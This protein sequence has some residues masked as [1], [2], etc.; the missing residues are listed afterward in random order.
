MLT[1][2]SFNVLSESCQKS[3]L[4]PVKTPEEIAKK[5]GVSLAKIH[6]Q[7]K[8]GTKVEHEH[9][10]DHDT[11]MHIALHHLDELPDYYTRL[12]KV[13]MNEGIVSR[14]RSVGRAAKRAV[15][16]SLPNPVRS[17][18]A[19]TGVTGMIHN[20]DKTPQEV[21]NLKRFRTQLLSNKHKLPK[22]P[23]S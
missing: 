21:A 11:A 20:T 4:K 3:I 8:Q 17:A 23:T 19:A 14:V 18:M 5:H 15:G 7:L 10:Q 2:K 22:F 12:K 1:Y 6:D 9:T 13:E 16:H